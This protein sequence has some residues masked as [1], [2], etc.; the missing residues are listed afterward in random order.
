MSKRTFDESIKTD[1]RKEHVLCISP[2]ASS[3]RYIRR[4]FSSKEKALEAEEK[5]KKAHSNIGTWVRLPSKDEMW[6]MY[7]PKNDM[8]DHEPWHANVID[9][10]SLLVEV[11]NV[12]IK[13]FRTEEPYH[14]SRYAS[15]RTSPSAV[16][17]ACVRFGEMV[18]KREDRAP[19]KDFHYFIVKGETELLLD[20]DKVETVD[21][22]CE[23]FEKQM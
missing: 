12:E 17:E 1:L 7:Y 19:R 16:D 2:T 8:L 22:L 23:R 14:T 18:K 4:L 20:S 6:D 10:D 5:L 9:D 15:F 21:E 13:T 11:V 3:S